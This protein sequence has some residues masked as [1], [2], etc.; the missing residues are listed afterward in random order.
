MAK[1][2]KCHLSARLPTYLDRTLCFIPPMMGFVFFRD[3]Q[4][5]WGWLLSHPNYLFKEL[6]FR[7]YPLTRKEEGPEA[8]LRHPLRKT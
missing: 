4:P 1:G 6:G 2:E 5:T 7:L 8:M 3:L